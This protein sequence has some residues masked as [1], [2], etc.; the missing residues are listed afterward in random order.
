MDGDWLSSALRSSFGDGLAPGRASGEACPTIARA[1]APRP[2]PREGGLIRG[3]PRL[4]GADDD[5]ED[6]LER[7][8]RRRFLRQE[9]LRRAA[10]AVS[11]LGEELDDEDARLEAEG[12]RLA[13]ERRKLEA[14]VALARHQHDLDNEEA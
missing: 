5:A 14:A 1:P 10:D 2:L 12:L 7:V 13:E 9:F 8:R 11:Q 6:V 3:P 4:L